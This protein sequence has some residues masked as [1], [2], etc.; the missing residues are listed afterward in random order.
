[1]RAKKKVAFLL[2]GILCFCAILF[3]GCGQEQI[4]VPDVITTP[5]IVI[6]S[7]GIVTEYL[8]GDFAKN[9]YNVG[10]LS[11]MVMEE[12]NQY[13]AA[14]PGEAEVTV[15]SVEMAADNSSNIVVTTEYNSVQAYKDYTSTELFYG[16]I[17][18]AK[19]AGYDLDI[20][21]TS[22]KDGTVVGE[23]EILGMEKRKIIITGANAEIIPPSSILY[24]NKGIIV[25]E[26]GTV[27][28]LNYFIIK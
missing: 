18:Q 20:E 9:Y 24:E 2:L 16:T 1:M 4:K 11:S 15:K 14:L 19:E 12:V 22:V 17:P 10:E 3:T 26:N 28:G 13:N 7:D 6:S 25:N 5:T 21:M 27:E 23:N 8:V